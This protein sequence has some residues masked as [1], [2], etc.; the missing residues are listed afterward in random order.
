MSFNIQN[1]IRQNSTDIKNYIND[2]HS[3]EEEITSKDKTLIKANKLNVLL[4]CFLI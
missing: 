2:L 4:E 3:W 1:Q